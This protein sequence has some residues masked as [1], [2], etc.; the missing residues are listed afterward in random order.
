MAS[1]KASEEPSFSDI[2]NN[3]YQDFEY[4][5]IETSDVI[6]NTEYDNLNFRPILLRT[7]CLVIS[8]LFF[9]GCIAMITFVLAKGNLNGGKFHVTTLPGYLAFRY[10]PAV[11]GT[12]TVLWWRGITCTLGRMTPYISLADKK[13]PSDGRS[14]LRT[15]NN[16][17]ANNTYMWN[18]KAMMFDGHHIL[19]TC[20]VL[21]WML[22]LALVPVKASLL[23]LT[24]DNSGWTVTPQTHFA[25][26]MIFVYVCLCTVAIY[27]TVYLRDRQT[28]V[29]W[30]PVSLADQLVLL[31]KSNL[32]K[33]LMKCRRVDLECD[34]CVRDFFKRNHSLFGH[35]RLGYWRHKRTG[36]IWHGIA[37]VSGIFLDFHYKSLLC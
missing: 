35:L 15:I 6:K 24:T 4:E 21:R 25:W 5:K 3:P 33:I 27:L 28:G 23:Q 1:T 29:R 30:D 12:V 17:Y 10:G 14:V 16:R 37:A 31:Q 34:H 20:V 7:W 26:F 13:P 22:D 2:T 18:F 36:E 9:V 11:V 19:F 8:L 32:M